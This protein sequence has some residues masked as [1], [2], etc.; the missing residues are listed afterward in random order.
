MCL[1]VY[2]AS[3][4]AL[5]REGS[6]EHITLHELDHSD[7]AV[8]QWLAQP[9]VARVSTGGECSCAFE[10]VIADHPIDY[11]DEMFADSGRDQQIAVARSLISLIR[12]AL[13]KS[14][15][16]EVYGVFDDR[17]TLQPHGSIAVELMDLTPEKFFFTEGFVYRVSA[18]AQQII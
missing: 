10:H 17:R 15:F 2:I 13:Q 11:F 4:Y 3:E 12:A 9:H 16:V 7:F 5:N 14:M 6:D 1:V 18:S 8:C